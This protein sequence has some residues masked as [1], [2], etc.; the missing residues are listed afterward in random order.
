[1]AY[2]C[3]DGFNSPIPLLPLMYVEQTGSIVIMVQQQEKADHLV[4]QNF[5]AEQGLLADPIRE[6]ITKTPDFRIL[7]GAETVAFCE[8]KYP[9]DIFTER[10][11]AAIR[12]APDGQIGGIIEHGHPS[13]QYR[14]LERAAT[15]AAAQFESINP[16]HSVPNVL[17]VVN[18]D[19][20]SYEDDFREVLIGYCGGIR[21]GKALRD[22]IPEI[23]AYVWI[24][25]KANRKSQ[26]RIERIFRHG[27]PCTGQQNPLK[28]TVRDLLKLG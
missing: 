7:R 11:T 20:Y 18:H 21:T 17:M 27:D 23:D 13:R 10:L 28:E 16:S 12:Q 25:R 3:G 24:D 4:V 14:C 22:D 19:A 15:K 1:M 26:E 2:T 5:F 9:Q 6:Q 8:V